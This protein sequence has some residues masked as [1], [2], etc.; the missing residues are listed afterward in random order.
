MIKNNVVIYHFTL[1]C[2]A[3]AESSNKPMQYSFT[4][5]LNKEEER[6]LE[7]FE[8]RCLR[9]INGTSLRDHITNIRIRRRLGLET[10]ITEVIRKR[11]LSWFGHVVRRPSTHFVTRAFRQDFSNPRPRGRPAK[12]WRDQIRSDTGLPIETLERHALD[13]G[14]WSRW[15]RLVGAR[16][17]HRLCI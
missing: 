12:R 7:V 13:R 4:W 16:G 6:K 10:T 14:G 3:S 15:S 9:A 8:M 5:T 2:G 17:D 11:R 1:E